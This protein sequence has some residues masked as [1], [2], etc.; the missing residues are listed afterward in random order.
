MVSF[1]HD[2]SIQNPNSQQK[3]SLLSFM[4]STLLKFDSPVC[5]KCTISVI[6]SWE[7]QLYS[8]LQEDA[9]CKIAVVASCHAF[10]LPARQNLV[11]HRIGLHSKKSALSI[12]N[13][14]VAGIVILFCKVGSKIIL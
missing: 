3:Q 14:F 2:N 9:A 5:S 12:H 7:L 1:I 13:I 4:E 8:P 10:D 6:W 11:Q